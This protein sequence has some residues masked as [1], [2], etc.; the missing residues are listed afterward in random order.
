M[1]SSF[2]V[3]WYLGW[4]GSEVRPQHC[5]GCLGALSWGSC[6]SW[7]GS[8]ALGW[9]QAGVGFWS[10]FCS[11][12]FVLGSRVEPRGYLLQVPWSLLCLILRQNFAELPRVALDL[13]PSCSSLLSNWDYRHAQPCPAWANQFT[14]CWNQVAQFACGTLGHTQVDCV[15]GLLP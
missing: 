7:C 14:G 5:H 4:G 12:I 6:P 3:L 13:R 2:L 9:H 11:F 10:A 1:A 15:G 8:L